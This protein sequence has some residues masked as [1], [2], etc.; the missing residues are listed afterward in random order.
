M[1]RTTNYSTTSNASPRNLADDGA[2]LLGLGGEAAVAA[3]ALTPDA[4]LLACCA[5]A[6]R[7]DAHSAA[8]FDAVEHLSSRHPLSVA[9]YHEAYREMPR[10]HDLVARAADLPARTP[11]GLR[12]KAELALSYLHTGDNDAEIALSVA[13]DVL[14][15]R[16]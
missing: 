12:A 15:G 7:I 8:T 9:A 5:E 1:P 3:A 16:A 11:E 6:L 10:F 13:R 4:E 14:A 2:A